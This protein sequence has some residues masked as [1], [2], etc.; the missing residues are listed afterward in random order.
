MQTEYHIKYHTH[1]TYKALVKEALIEFL[2]T[3]CQDDT[4]TVTQL[5]FNNS[6]HQEVYQHLN[7]LEFQ[8]TSIRA[9]KPFNELE[10]SMTATVE[11]TLPMLSVTS[12]P[13]E[14]EQA[15]LASN[16]FFID[17]HL[18]LG[19][20]KYTSILDSYH[21]RLLNRTLKQPVINYLKQLN[22]YLHE[23]LEFDPVPTNVHTTASEVFYLGKGVCQD[24]THLFL[25]IARQNRIPSR[26]VSGYLNQGNNLTGSAVMH[27]WAECFIPGFGWLGFDPTNNLLAGLDHIKAAHGVDYSD[28]SPIKGILKTRGSNKTSYKVDVISKMM[29]E[30]AQ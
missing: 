6:L 1:H 15:V 28:C 22:Q 19:F 7:P 26:Y 18:Y 5:N 30:S 16:D 20:T 29:A 4:Q 25:A 8:V 3:P 2:V 14:E 17:H 24:Y 13:F 12:L 21:D 11:K 10:F 27:A 9:K 23:L